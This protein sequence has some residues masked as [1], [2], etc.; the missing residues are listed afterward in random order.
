MKSPLCSSSLS[1]PPEVNQYSDSYKHPLAFLR[2]FS[3]ETKE[4]SDEHLIGNCFSVNL[5]TAFRKYKCQTFGAKILM[6]IFKPFL[7]K[8]PP[9]FV[10]HALGSFFLQNG[11]GAKQKE[12]REG[13][14]SCALG[15]LPF[16]FLNQSTRIQLCPAHCASSRRARASPAALMRT[17]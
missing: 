1:N 5:P 3:N 10:H 2:K 8:V 14:L 17:N 15:A 13:S 7:S 6:Q 4:N 16:S 12:G 9:H 11:S